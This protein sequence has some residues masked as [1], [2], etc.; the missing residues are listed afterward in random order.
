MKKI[1]F[2]LLAV[3]ILFLSACGSTNAATST[4]T[5]NQVVTS[6]AASPATIQDMAPTQETTEIS[7]GTSY[8]NALPIANQLLLG[9]MALGG[10]D[11]AVTAEQANTLLPL[12]NDFKTSSGG[13]ENLVAAILAAMTPAQIQAIAAM[14]ITQETSRVILQAQGISMGGPQNNG[15]LS[16][17]GGGTPPD[18]NQQ[19]PQGTPPA[20][21]PSNGQ[22]GNPDQSGS[23]PPEMIDALIHILQNRVAGTTN[24]A[25]ASAAPSSS[26]TLS[27]TTAAYK[28]DGGTETQ[29]GQTY[30]AT[31][32]DESA[33]YVTNG[34]SLTLADGTI[35]STGDTS[36]TDNSSFYGLNAAVLAE[37]GS[38]I[39]LSGSTVTTSGTGAN[40]VFATGSGSSVT[41]ENV[42]IH[43][44]G[45]GGHG[46]MAT[47]GGTMT[48]TNVDMTTAGASSGAIATDRGGGTINVTGG[49][50]TTSGQ[51]SPD[52]YS[53]GDITVTG[54][55]LTATGAESAVIEGANSITLNDTDLSS[56]ME[57]KWGVMIYQSM[58][59]DAQGTR[60]NFTMTGGSLTNTAASGPLFYI[61]NSTAVVTLEGVNVSAAS[62]VLVQ[63]SAGNWG[64]SG[65]NGGT[66]I[67]TI[68]RQTLTGDML[69]DSI[70]SISVTL[71]EG[72][73]LSGALNP[74]HEAGEVNLTLDSSSIW[75]VTADSYLTCLTDDA[76]ITGSS[77]TNI[78][79][80]GHTVYY[81][82]SM[83]SM[84]GSATYTLINGGFLKPAE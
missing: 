53:T 20:G 41:I 48:L 38:T 9:T 69:A 4:L 68:N 40:G 28:Q 42:T 84:L 34:G 46:V 23:M 30:A 37:A 70:S 62:G 6:T 21:N 39:D 10:T 25:S 71:Q 11:F 26:S 58:S 29:T 24:T 81:E 76:G 66:L 2:T 61:T 50:V 60:G 15:T 22:A 35:T 74:D 75:T 79:G 43:A 8:A 31:Q 54:G 1:L 51:N 55:T 27:T 33:V 44:T 65:S 67:L 56:S 82:G 59:G 32:T 80:N 36:S 77:I 16:E 73:S 3:L 63:A 49:N 47:Q 14:Q 57:N 83:C 7:L 18:A 17:N 45:N 52:I 64:N 13:T 5:T 19:P 78:T 12:W 72:S